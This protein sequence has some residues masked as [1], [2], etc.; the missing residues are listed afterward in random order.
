M[1]KNIFE[2]LRSFFIL[3]LFLLIGEWVATHFALGIPASIWGLLLLFLSLNLRLI[4][5]NWVLFSAKLLTRYMAILFIPVSVGVVKYLDL[6]YEQASILL[7]P[8]ILST[9][10]TLVCIG[11][12]SQYLFSQHSFSKLRQKVLKQREMEK[13]K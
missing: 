1:L 11:L 7:L 6:L 10:L 4:P 3:Y 2:L 5:L 8:N 13:N 12:L 9:T